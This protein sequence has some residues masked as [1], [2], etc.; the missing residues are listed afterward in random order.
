MA[1]TGLFSDTD[2]TISFKYFNVQEWVNLN[3]ICATQARWETLNSADDIRTSF[4]VVMA[5]YAG[6]SL[7]ARICQS[8]TA[9]HLVEPEGGS[10]YSQGPANSPYHEPN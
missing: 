2:F 7:Q 8:Q 10:P 4:E 3:V 9:L 5:H 1:W 6:Q